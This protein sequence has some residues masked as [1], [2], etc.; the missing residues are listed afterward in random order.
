MASKKGEISGQVIIYALSLIVVGVILLFGYS[1]IQK[2]MANREQGSYVEFKSMFTTMINDLVSSYGD[3]KVY[4]N[5][6]PLKVPGGFTQLCIIDINVKPSGIRADVNGIIL[7]SWG[8]GV[9]DNVFLLKGN[10]VKGSFYAGNITVINYKKDYQCFDIN[11]ERV[12]GI[13][14]EGMGRRAALGE[15][16]SAH[17]STKDDPFPDVICCAQAN[18]AGYYL[19]GDFTDLTCYK[20]YITKRDPAPYYKLIDISGKEGLS[21]CCGVEKITGVEL[22]G[23]PCGQKA[24]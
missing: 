4:D 1:A 13:R 8:S 7:D 3:V 6:L 19:T 17:K 16:C 12:S 14:L 24:H 10:K 20:D 22:K 9:N 5:S 11:N 15:S 18:C 23:L 21:Q 2:I